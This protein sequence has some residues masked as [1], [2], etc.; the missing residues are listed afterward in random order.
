[1]VAKSVS[2][3]VRFELQIPSGGTIVLRKLSYIT[4][5]TVLAMVGAASAQTFS[6]IQ[7]RTDGASCSECAGAGGTGTKAAFWIKQN[8][9]SPSMTGHAAQL[10][11]GGS[12]PYSDAL[13]NWRIA[14]DSSKMRHYV[15]DTY[16]YV[17][18]PSAVQ[19]LEFNIT[20][21]DHGRGYTYGFTCSVKSGGVWKISVPDDSTSSMAEMH[22]SSTGIS[23]PAPPANTWNHISFEAER[24]SSGMIHYISLTV[25]GSTHYINKTV[26]APQRTLE[27][28]RPHYAHPVE[29]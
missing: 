23:C 10:F 2:N 17:T 4:I 28:E 18:N 22:W 25:N 7:A 24:T 14:S 16:Y 26:Y 27:L 8:V 21:Y 1:M 6:N 19:G 3:S 13:W 15:F 5:L 20:S 12:T 29:W 9:A 11:L